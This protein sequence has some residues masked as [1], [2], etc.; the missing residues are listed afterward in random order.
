MNY[1]SVLLV[2]SDTP[3]IVYV[4]GFCLVERFSPEADI[5]CAAYTRSRDT[6]HVQ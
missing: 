2:T 3:T 6:W 1:L 4:R 5:S